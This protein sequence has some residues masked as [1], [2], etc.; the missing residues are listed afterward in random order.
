MSNSILVSC[1]LINTQQSLDSIEN[2]AARSD[3]PAD[4]LRR[5]SEKLGC[6]YPELVFNGT[7]SST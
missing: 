3:I 1:L 4:F 6:K 5:W 7:R 2:G